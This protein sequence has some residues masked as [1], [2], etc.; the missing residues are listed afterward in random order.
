MFSG[1]ESC[2]T[3]QAGGRPSRFLGI[4][5]LTIGHSCLWHGTWA[6]SHLR[7]RGPWGVHE[8]EAILFF[9]EPG[10]KWNDHFYWL[11]VVSLEIERVRTE[12]GLSV[13]RQPG[14]SVPVPDDFVKYFH[15]TVGQRR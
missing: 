1:R 12:L 3:N 9:Y 8:G 14:W 11:R 13:L 7:G 10:L 15:L 6:R 2:A 5:R 4:S